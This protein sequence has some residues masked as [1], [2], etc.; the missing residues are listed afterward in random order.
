MEYPSPK[1]QKT[2]EG[3]FAG[4]KDIVNLIFRKE[5]ETAQRVGARYTLDEADKL[6][7]NSISDAGKKRIASDLIAH[8]MEYMQKQVDQLPAPEPG[9][10]Y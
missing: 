4:M 9:V 6:F 1:D 5:R 8:H 2:M 10:D 3:L 7:W